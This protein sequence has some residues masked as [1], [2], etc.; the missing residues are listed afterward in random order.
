MAQR[1]VPGAN[2]YHG[3]N[4]CKMSTNP[5]VSLL[6][7]TAAADPGTTVRYSTN[8]RDV[9]GTNLAQQQR[10]ETNTGDGL[11]GVSPART[12]PGQSPPAGP[13]RGVGN[14]PDDRRRRTPA[15]RPGQ[16]GP[17][18]S[19]PRQARVSQPD[20]APRRAGQRLPALD[21][22][23]QA[24]PV[25]HEVE[26]HRVQTVRGVSLDP[27]AAEFFPAGGEDRDEAVLVSPD[28]IE[29]MLAG[30]D[31]EIETELQDLIYSEMR[32]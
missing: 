24:L 20:P 8:A 2:T 17:G 31:D 7:T 30:V 18:Q 22:P 27:T 10:R 15:S 14:G 11:L 6:V 29:G 32:S 28:F 21:R 19:T 26:G 3:D 5:G 9:T 23:A 25:E 1:V 4:A 16:E 12:R 13:H